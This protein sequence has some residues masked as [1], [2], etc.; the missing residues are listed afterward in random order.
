L[1]ICG[2]GKKRPGARRDPLLGKA[3]NS[4]AKWMDERDPVKKAV[5][6]IKMSRG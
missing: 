5:R 6:L 3:E 4:F 1:Y 2:Q